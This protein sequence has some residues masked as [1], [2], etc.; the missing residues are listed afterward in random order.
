MATEAYLLL[1]GARDS[2]FIDSMLNALGQRQAVE[3][4][5]HLRNGNPQS[6][7][8]A[9]KINPLEAK[10]VNKKNRPHLQ[11][12][13]AILSGRVDSGGCHGNRGL[14]APPRV[15]LRHDTLHAG[16]GPLRATHWA[17]GFVCLSG[18]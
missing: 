9:H 6:V 8:D 2:W 11:M 4:R 17:S 1:T 18:L 7:A 5:D 3:L 10:E 15:S 12:A 13:R 14:C 16:R